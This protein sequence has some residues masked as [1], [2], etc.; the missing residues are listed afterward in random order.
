M[1][2]LIVIEIRKGDKMSDSKEMKTRGLYEKEERAY[3]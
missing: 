1:I 3:K 2:P